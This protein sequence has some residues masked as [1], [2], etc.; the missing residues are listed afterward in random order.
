MGG[1]DSMLKVTVYLALFFV[2]ILFL[3]N[4]PGCNFA[5]RT[6]GGTITVNLPDNQ[7][8]VNATWKNNSL[9][10]LTKPMKGEDVAETYTFKEDANFGVMEG[11]VTFVEHKK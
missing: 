3:A 10:Y 4:V 2:L 8:L 5:A 1:A 7:K 9:W 6:F 11:T